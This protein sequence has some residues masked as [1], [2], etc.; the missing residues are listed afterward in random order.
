MTVKGQCLRV[1]VCCQGALVGEMGFSG[2]GSCCSSWFQSHRKA[3]KLHIRQLGGS[4]S[5]SSW[6]HC[7]GM[8]F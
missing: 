7:L 6:T 2:C 1:C 4:S 3:G 8:P 5:L